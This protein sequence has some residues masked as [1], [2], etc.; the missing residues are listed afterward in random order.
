[1]R[2]G[3]RLDRDPR[4]RTTSNV[5]Y[6]YDS[7]DLLTKACY[8]VS[9]RGYGYDTSSNLTAIGRVVLGLVVEQV[10]VEVDGRPGGVG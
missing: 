2:S 5:A 9:T 7:R 1:M 4:N 8:A 10:D 3:I 6:E